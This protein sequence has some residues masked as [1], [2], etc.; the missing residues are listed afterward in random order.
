MTTSFARRMERKAHD[1]AEL[2]PDYDSDI[3][4]WYNP[5]CMFEGTAER[6][7]IGI[8]PRL[9]RSTQHGEDRS[10]LDFECND[11]AYNDWIDGRWPGSGSEHQTKVRDVF[12]ALYGDD[13]W[14]RVLRDTPCFNVCPLRTKSP[15]DISDS[16]W[17]EYVS[18][19]HEIILHLKPS[20][21]ICNGN[22]EDYGG[23]LGKS[24]WNAVRT[25][26]NVEPISEDPFVVVNRHND[27]EQCVRLKRGQVTSGDLTGADVIGMPQ[28]TRFGELP[29]Y[30]LLKQLRHRTT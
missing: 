16:V 23:Q 25:K 20:T 30:E 5:R 15:K 27:E 6:V 19:S 26:F 17:K 13:A 12:K 18:W 2:W 22:S 3:K 24:P 29:L 8:N 4:C 21:I 7:F 11:G 10:Y 9:E 14:E 28:L 1:I